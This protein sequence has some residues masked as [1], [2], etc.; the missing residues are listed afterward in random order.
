[1]IGRKP[2]L[3]IERLLE[4]TKDNRNQLILNRRTDYIAKYI[5]ELLNHYESDKNPKDLSEAQDLI[6]ELKAL[7]PDLFEFMALEAR[8][9]DVSGRYQE[10]ENMYVKCIE[11]RPN[12]ARSLNNLAW[13]KTL[14]GADLPEALELINKATANASKI[15]VPELLDTRSVIHMKLGDSQ[16]AIADLN[17]AIAVNPT[18]AKYFH[19]AQ[20]Q[21]QAGNKPAAVEALGKAGPKGTVPAGLHALEAPA[22]EKLI[23][24]LGTH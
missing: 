8:F 16:K 9:F 24:D 6:E 3:S 13:L 18:A 22:Y 17:Q 19:L 12:D 21:L 7:R 20:A 5:E 1:M 11:K 2:T 4:K 14:R 10:A 15:I 23:K